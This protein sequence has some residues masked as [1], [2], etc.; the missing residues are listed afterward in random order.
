MVKKLLGF[1]YKESGSLNQAALLLGFFAFLAQLLGFLRDRLL[2]HVFGA[3]PDLDIYYA[4][5]RVPDFMFVT[6]ASVVSLSVLVP[7]IV[8]RDSEDAREGS[9]ERKNLHAFI[10]SVFSFFVILMLSTAIL[11]FVFMPWISARLFEGLSPQSL[12][13]VVSLSRLLLVSPIILGLSNLFGSLTQ[14]YNR[15]TTYAIS[16]ILYNAGIVV[17]VIFFGEKF[18]VEGVAWG[19][20]LGALMHASIQLPFITREGLLPKI[21]WKPDFSMI[22]K[23]VR[24]S[25]PRT[26]TLSMSSISLIALVS[27]ASRMTEGSISILSFSTNLQGVPLSLIGVSYSLAAF[28]IL[29]R[30]FQEKNLPAFVEQMQ[31]TSRFIIFWS[32]PLT[33][34]LVVLRA[35]I[36]RVILGTGLFDWQA[37]RLTAAALALF[38]LSALFQSLML[39]FTRGFYSAGITKRP[40]YINLFSTALLL[41]TAYALVGIFELSETFRFFIATLLKVENSP[42]SAVL[43]LPLSFSLGTIVNCLIHWIDFEREFEGFTR[44]VARSFFQGVGVSVIMGAAAYVGLGVFGDWFA[45]ET[46]LGIFLQGLSAGLLA[47]LTG[48]IVLI[49]LK[50]RELASVWA[51][52]S[53]KFRPGKVIATDPE[54]V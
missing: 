12:E 49:G 47:I 29:T 54:I 30:R 21:A 34:L 36:V 46:L 1:L 50:S 27:F 53:G 8:E 5:F 3:G 2:A 13:R 42:A 51:A 25:F 19:V 40:F 33:A 41:I 44:G 26:L 10:D 39:L 4:A 31:N 16:P 45:T 7:F 24:I 35:Q 20:I 37:T 22:A 11:A 52:L 17:G 28:P 23:V 14:A 15:F 43:M 9:L 18:G 32:L 48:V 6:V 38:A